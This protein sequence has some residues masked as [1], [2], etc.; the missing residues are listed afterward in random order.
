LKNLKNK[1]ENIMIHNKGNFF[2]K[3]M[4]LLLSYVYGV[5]IKI[6]T[7]L[8]NKNISKI[9]KLPCKIISIGNIT[10]GG[11]GKTPTTIYTACLLKKMGYNVAVISRGYGGN[12]QDSFGIVS[13][14]SNILLKPDQAGD[15]PYLMALKLDGIPI[16]VAKKR[17]NAGTIACNKFKSDLIILD[18]AFQH[19]SLD[20]DCDIVLLDSNNPFGSG[21]LIPRGILREPLKNLL[22]SNA[23]VFTRSKGELPDCT[24]KISKINNNALFFQCDH[25]P[26]ALYSID[27]NGKT[28][29]NT[30]EILCNKKIF[31]FSG[32]AKNWDFKNILLSLNYQLC[33]FIMFPDHHKYNKED[34]ENIFDQA[35]KSD[36][37]AIVTTEKD[38]VKINEYLINKIPVYA[39]GIKIEFKQKDN[40][41]NFL[42]KILIEEL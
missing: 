28:T 16:L 10:V 42:K 30:L 22:R 4:L 21:H 3:I 9:Q 6:R 15:E 12:I 20:R 19:R 5:I 17:Y 24:A 40:Y 41:I 26:E 23:F 29:K 2:L 27:N 25:F 33:N 11:T 34:I 35:A 1:I 36:A 32:I 14:G 37:Y 8:Y 7:F 18:D 39:L 38:F 31:A 13:D